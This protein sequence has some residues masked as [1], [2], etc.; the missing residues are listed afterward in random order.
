M[1]W[2]IVVHSME[3]CRL[4]AGQQQG[5]MGWCK[6]QQE[7]PSGW[8]S[9]QAWFSHVMNSPSSGS[10]TSINSILCSLWTQRHPH[11][12]RLGATHCV[13]RVRRCQK[14]QK[15][16]K[17]GAWIST[18]WGRLSK[19]KIILTTADICSNSNP[20][21]QPE[22]LSFQPQFLIPNWPEYPRWK[23]LD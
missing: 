19:V 11:W 9:S 21:N 14:L 12:S 16:G 8:Q 23:S 1:P 4:Q 13:W 15:R 3:S 17:H 18:T 10:L 2:S 7:A 6:G 5:H 20:Q 22:E